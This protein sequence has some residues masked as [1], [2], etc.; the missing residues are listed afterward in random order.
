M[1]DNK[2]TRKDPLSE[3]VRQV[4]IENDI[5]RQVELTLNEQLG[6][7]SRKQLPH[8]LHESYDATLNEA[9]HNA[10][11]ENC[12]W[13]GK[14]MEE[15]KLAKTAGAAVL[16]A[17]LGTV[18]GHATKP[19]EPPMTG[20][21]YSDSQRANLTKRIETMKEESKGSEPRNAKERDL[22]AK[23]PPY[24]KITH[25]DVLKG[26]GV[27]AQEEANKALG[28][29]PI[30]RKDPAAPQALE[31]KSSPR[32]REIVHHELSKFKKGELHSGSKKGPEVT[33]RKQAIAI[34]LDVARR[35]TGESM[36]KKKK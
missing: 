20:P 9:I 3:S 26:R 32:A 11:N 7:Q 19:K 34:A 14:K 4:M 36:G 23:K 6:I 5:R 22:A 24:D 2:F 16:G 13:S 18:A 33:K 27:I 1:F 30:T 29:N 8:E 28:G 31:E 17:T 10:L 35:K 25:A 12:G 21:S 15:G